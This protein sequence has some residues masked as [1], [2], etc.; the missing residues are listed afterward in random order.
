MEAYKS[1]SARQVMFN[2]FKIPNSFTLENSFFAR[3]SEQEL[4][5]LQEHFDKQMRKIKTL[6]LKRSQSECST[7]SSGE[8]QPGSKNRGSS[9]NNSCIRI[10]E[11]NGNNSTEKNTV[12][13]QRD[14]SRLAKEEEEES[15]DYHDKQEL[16]SK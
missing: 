6:R 16:T 12:P 4:E 14:K 7:N 15:C 9:Q 5:V 2:E 8:P 13:T 3:F 11:E 10:Q 1:G